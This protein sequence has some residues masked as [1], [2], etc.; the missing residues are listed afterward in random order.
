MPIFMKSDDVKGEVTATGHLEEIELNSFQFGV[1]IGVSS[2]T[3]GGG[4]RT[5]S[6]ASISE[7]TVSKQLDNASGLIFDKLCAGTALPTVSI[8]FTRASG[9]DKAGND[10]YLTIELE[11]VLFSGW[12]ISSGGDIPSESVSLNFT[13]IKMSYMKGDAE[14]GLTQGTIAGWDLAKNEAAA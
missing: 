4:K 10:A 11:D 6:A 14:A 13:K 2:P 8:L 5:T 3:A 1:G 12:S 9:K 7:I